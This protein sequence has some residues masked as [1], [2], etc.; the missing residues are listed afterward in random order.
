MPRHKKDA[1]IGALSHASH[2]PDDY[3]LI[4]VAMIIIGVGFKLSLVP[5]HLWTPDI[6]EGAPAPVTGFIAVV[7]KIAMFA[8]IL[9]YFVLAGSPDDKSL[10]TGLIAIAILS[11]IAGNLLGW[12]QKNLKRL[13]AYSSVVHFGHL[14]VAFLA[15]GHFGPQAAAHY[16]AAYAVTNLGAFGVIGLLRPPGTGCDADRIED[17]RGLF[18]THPFL[19]DRLAFMMLSLA[20]ISPTMGFIAKFYLIGR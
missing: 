10:R 14:L 4:G 19:A 1:R 15:A 8:V 13:L 9:R 11:M 16:L 3:R 12:Q 7:S 17:Y 18:C 6:Y 20:G 5:F 2:A